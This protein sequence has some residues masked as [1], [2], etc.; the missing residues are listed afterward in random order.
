M[1][2]HGGVNCQS[3]LRVRK[4]IFGTVYKRQGLEQT[5]AAISMEVRLPPMVFIT[6]RT[7]A[8]IYPPQYL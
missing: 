5:T 7:L 8:I 2:I 6:D 1:F 3:L 4:D